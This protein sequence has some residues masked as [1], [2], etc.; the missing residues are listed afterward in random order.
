MIEQLFD[1]LMLAL[2]WQVLLAILLGSIG[3][4]IVGALPGLSSTLGVALLIPFTFGLSAPVAFGLLGG[5]YCSSIY[6]GSITAILINTPGTGAAAAT[7][8][9]G[10]PMTQ[11]GQAGKALATAI[12]SSFFGGVF[13]TAALLVMAPPL[14]QIALRFGPPET[15]TVCLFGLTIIASVS[16]G[17]MLK[18]ILSGLIGLLIG[19][20]GLDLQI[21]FGRFTFARFELYNGINLVLALVGFFSIPEALNMVKDRHH[22]IDADKLKVSDMKLSRAEAKFLFPTWLRSSVIGTLIGIIPGVGTPVA[23]FASYNEAK[24]FS[25]R[26]DQFGTGIIEGVAAPEAA[27][28]AVEGGS[29][30]PLLTLGIPGSAQTAIYLGALMIQG[31]NPG[32]SMFQ[33]ANAP[34]TYSIIFGLMIAN[35]VM[36]GVGLGGIRAFLALIRLKKIVMIP[37]IITFAVIGSYALNYRLFDVQIMLLLGLAGYF[38]RKNGIP[39]APAVIAIILGPLGEDAFLQ[40]NTIFRGNL[41]MF[42]TRPICVFFIALTLIT[43]A[44]AVNN[45]RKEKKAL[46]S[47]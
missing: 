26:K 42:F 17:S 8:L 27:N 33:G 10:Y 20:V 36:L 24:R 32:P 16:T 46:A 18:G 34:I 2:D 22:V 37:L 28:N 25:K 11:K 41:L 21:G 39:L 19:T 6:G 7:V 38:M 47:N 44:V 12:W 43:I 23:C 13:S 1:G 35:F 14:S 15:F 40:S 5:M 31:I 4:I 29:M 3:G 45:H 30:I 9:D